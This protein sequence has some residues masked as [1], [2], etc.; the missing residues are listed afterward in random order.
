MLN[1][2]WK[3][4]NP[5]HQITNKFKLNPFRVFW[6]MGRAHEISKFK[7][8]SEK[9]C[10]EH[11]DFDIWYCLLFAIWSLEFINPPNIEQLPRELSEGGITE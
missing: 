3:I 7:I 1:R 11:L 9:V 4:P 2:L 10:F 6:D 5:K 8:S